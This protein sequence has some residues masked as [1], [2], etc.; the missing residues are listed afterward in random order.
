MSQYKI[1]KHTIS[2]YARERAGYPSHGKGRPAAQVDG[3]PAL[4]PIIGWAP[5][6][7]LHTATQARLEA[8]LGR[9]TSKVALGRLARAGRILDRLE[10]LQ[11]RGPVVL[12]QL[13]VGPLGA[14]RERAEA[15]GLD[16]WR[17]A[18]LVCLRLDLL[19]AALRKEAGRLERHAETADTLHRQA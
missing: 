2:T 16:S 4:S 14:L 1:S 17:L 5:P 11:E 19:A 6:G 12:A 9:R 3:A 7:L 8:W 10:R 18:V 13:P 15:A